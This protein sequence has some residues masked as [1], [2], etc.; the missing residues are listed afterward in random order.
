[1][2]PNATTSRAI[3]HSIPP[4]HRPEHASAV[5]GSPASFSA[6]IASATAR[7]RQF[8]R[9][10]TAS[11]RFARCQTLAPP[12]FFGCSPFSASFSASLATR[13]SR[14]SI[15]ASRRLRASRS[16]IVAAAGSD[17]SAASFVRS[18]TFWS[19]LQFKTQQRRDATLR[20]LAD[21]GSYRWKFVGSESVLQSSDQRASFPLILPFR[22]TGASLSES[23]FTTN[24]LRRMFLTSDR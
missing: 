24:S 15:A 5:A 19:P 16:R 11:S 2:S 23:R 4:L 6:M 20:A 14:R 13:R 17:S 8:H 22:R 9:P 3:R 1:M 21:C 7:P 18:V 12:L 10:T